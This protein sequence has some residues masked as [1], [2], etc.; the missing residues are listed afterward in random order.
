M[1]ARKP[2]GVVFVLSILAGCAQ[3]NID[4]SGVFRLQS[5]RSLPV[6][7]DWTLN[8]RLG[9]KTRDES[10]S[11]GIIWTHRLQDNTI[12]LSGPFGQGAVR[13]RVN[14]ART[15]IDDGEHVHIY[16][17]PADRLLENYL[18]SAIPVRALSYWVVGRAQPD[19]ELSE[20]D[21]GFKQRGWQ[22]RFEEMQVVNGNRLPR[23]IVLR[24]DNNRIKLIIDRWEVP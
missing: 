12:E 23:K 4:S 1:T 16:Q 6:V 19:T 13:L 24:K 9:V 8:G 17:G 2:F 5:A 10:F 7:L 20:V 15:V 22:V 11:A 21:N 18:G 14:D 3:N